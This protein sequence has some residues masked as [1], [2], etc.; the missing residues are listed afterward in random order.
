MSSSIIS[1]IDIRAVPFEFLCYFCNT[2][3][4]TVA[5]K[6]T[7]MVWT[8]LDSFLMPSFLDFSFM[9]TLHS[10]LTA[11]IAKTF[12]SIFRRKLLRNQR[13]LIVS[14]K[15]LSCVTA[16]ENYMHLPNAHNAFFLS[17]F[18]LKSFYKLR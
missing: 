2:I 14:R 7:Y 9:T 18:P 12:F 8:V 3:I 17:F 4:F 16:C 13:F 10:R 15:F 11:L 6:Q 1:P 5:Q